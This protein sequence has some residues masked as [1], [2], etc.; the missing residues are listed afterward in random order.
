MEELKRY[1]AKRFFKFFDFLSV[2]LEPLPAFD[3][4]LLPRDFDVLGEPILKRLFLFWLIIQKLV[5]HL[6]AVWIVHKAQKC[7]TEVFIDIFM[8]GLLIILRFFL[9]LLFFLGFH[10]VLTSGLIIWLVITRLVIRG[11]SP[12]VLNV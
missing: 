11:C 2:I 9:F 4:V 1:Y 8:L 12:G 6:L 5:K 7:G 3:E 10:L